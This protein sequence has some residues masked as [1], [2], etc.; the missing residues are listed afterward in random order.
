MPA[1]FP[2]LADGVGTNGTHKDSLSLVERA[3]FAGRYAIPLRV[4]PDL[5]QVAEN[6]SHPS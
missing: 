4:V 2:S 5:G 1:P 6:R 3:E